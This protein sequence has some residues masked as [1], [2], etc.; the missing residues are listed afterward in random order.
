MGLQGSGES[1]NPLGGVSKGSLPGTSLTLL[2]SSNISAGSDQLSM[3][4]FNQIVYI[5]FSDVSI[6]FLKRLQVLDIKIRM[7]LTSS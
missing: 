4:H 1:I 5:H 2:D 3:A 6:N 7:D